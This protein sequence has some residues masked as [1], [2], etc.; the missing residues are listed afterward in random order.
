MSH[1]AVL[2][3]EALL[4]LDV[5]ADGNYID[6]TFGRGGHSARIM[7]K[8]KNGKLIAIDKDLSAVAVAQEK[9]AGNSKFCIEHASF[10]NIGNIARKH[11]VYGKVNGVLLDLGMSSPQL[12]EAARGFS[13]MHDGPLDMRMDTTQILDAKKFVNEAQ[14]EEL[15][16]VF[17]E[18][19]EERFAKRIA[20]HIVLA[21]FINPINT[22]KELADIVAKAHP[23]WS[24]YRHP[25]TLVFQALR[26]Y[27]NN[28]LDDLKTCLNSCIDLL[29]LGGRLAVISFH[30]LEDRVVKNFMRQTPDEPVLP[31]NIP[32]KF[33]PQNIRFQ[34]LGKA[35]KPSAFEIKNN[36]RSRSAVLRI[37]E[38]IA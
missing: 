1:K 3:E 13:F 9:F 12:D 21:R 20:H 36:V 2:L 25:A 8:L 29:A 22:T 4:G 6:A 31:K 15:A 33:T 28:E 11:E 18:Y 34:K 7:E 5:A 17:K 14:E 16:M 30:S 24:R 35:I 10:A 26:I 37:G 38:K 19:G 23:A 27:V 32:I